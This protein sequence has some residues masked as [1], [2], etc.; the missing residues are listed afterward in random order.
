[1]PNDVPGLY[2]GEAALLDLILLHGNAVHV[3][4]AIA[5]LR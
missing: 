2:S 1:M 4:V 5:P 3:T